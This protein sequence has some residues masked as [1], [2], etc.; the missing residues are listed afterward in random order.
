V[1]FQFR[2]IA[3]SIASKL[4]VP[5]VSIPAA[6]A[7]KHFGILADFVSLDNPVSSGWTRQALGWAPEQ[8]RLLADT[9]ARYFQRPA[10]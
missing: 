7:A 1:L 2:D 5:A 6:K 4:Q 10:S 8:E 9:D 3:S